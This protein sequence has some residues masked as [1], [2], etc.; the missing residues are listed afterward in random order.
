MSSAERRLMTHVRGAGAN[1]HITTFMISHQATRRPRASAAPG[2]HRPPPPSFSKRL[3][4][5][6]AGRRRSDPEQ[7]R[8]DRASEASAHPRSSDAEGLGGPPPRS[9][10]GGRPVRDGYV[11]APL[12]SD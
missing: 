12:E 3:E 1:G 7:R 5:G 2:P 10:H 6:P 4:G 11:P 9:G 8:L